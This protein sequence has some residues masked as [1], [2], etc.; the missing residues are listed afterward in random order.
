M[1]LCR[2]LWLHILPP[3]LLPAICLFDMT[4]RLHTRLFLPMDLVVILALMIVLVPLHALLVPAKTHAPRL[5]IAHRKF[6]VSKI[7]MADLLVLNRALR[8]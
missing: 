1:L 4:R 5:T 7:R 2:C 3:L 6:V 8:F